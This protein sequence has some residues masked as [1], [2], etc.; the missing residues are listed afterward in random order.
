MAQTATALEKG[1]AGPPAF[2]SI[3]A[4]DVIRA[5]LVQRVVPLDFAALLKP[6]KRQGRLS[7]R[8]EN[9]PQR[10]RLSAGRNNGDG[11]WSVASDELEG[12]TYS[13]PS[14][15]AVAHELSI[16]IMSFDNETA[17]T[18]KLT[19][20]QIPALIDDQETPAAES[21]LDLKTQKR[22]PLLRSQL[23]KMQ[24]LFAVRESDLA[25]L[26]TALE[27]AKIESAA[28]LASARAAWEIE[29][30]ERLAE[31]SAQD[32]AQKERQDALWH[33]QQ[34]SDQARAES[35]L[36]RKIADEKN[37]W[38]KHLDQ[39]IDAERSRISAQAEERLASDR[40][41]LEAQ[42]QH[43]MEAELKRWQTEKKAE[44]LRA[45]ECWRA[46]EASRSAAALA[47]WQQQSTHVLA[48]QADKFRKLEEE[49][50]AS[51]KQQA[52]IPN[53]EVGHVQLDQ[54]ERQL[55]TANAALRAREIEIAK[56]RAAWELER[57]NWRQ[58]VDVSMLAAAKTWKNEEAAR[59]ETAIR[60]S[61]AQLEEAL[62]AANMR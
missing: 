52:N 15:L 53:L 4:S 42:F 27:Q 6:F 56:D 28:D 43:R 59:T 34:K 32:N 48:E 45:E 50:R 24:S 36:E 2:A 40:Q 57:G 41:K 33:A 16:R 13:V 23:E 18:L 8:V 7:L 38:K 61:C 30:K 10:A 19:R 14:N 1:K 17:S 62:D 51:L 47:E 22:D 21:D 54:L 46:E 44:L 26:R 9:V 25:E 5:P 60:K 31:A 20:Y 58:Q 37:S 3:S 39:K 55:E 29:L 12:L 11:S 49:L 35:E